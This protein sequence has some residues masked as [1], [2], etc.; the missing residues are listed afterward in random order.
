MEISYLAAA[1]QKLKTKLYA[2]KPCRNVIHYNALLAWIYIYT[3]TY[4]FK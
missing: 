1:S 4:I 2:N 3:Y